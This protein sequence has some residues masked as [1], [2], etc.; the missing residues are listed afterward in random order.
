MSF[1]DRF[2]QEI[3][4]YAMRNRNNGFK[5]WL[6]GSEEQFNNDEILPDNIHSLLALVYLA[7]RRA[8]WLYEHQP[9]LNDKHLPFVRASLQKAHTI[10]NQ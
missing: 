4:G 6:A 7:Y 1:C 10:N 3:D 8:R 5:E 2:S 9:E